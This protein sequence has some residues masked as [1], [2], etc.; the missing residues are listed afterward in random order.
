MRE[1]ILGVERGARAEAWRVGSL[2]R[3]LD[4]QAQLAELV[5]GLPRAPARH[6]QREERDGERRGS[7]LA[8][9]RVA[10]R[11]HEPSRDGDIESTVRST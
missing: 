6:D 3:A 4:R 11:A 7:E 2:H 8:R 1:L 5:L 10:R 9:E